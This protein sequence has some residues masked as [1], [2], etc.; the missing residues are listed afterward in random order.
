MSG[1]TRANGRGR[2]DD[3]SRGGVRALVRFTGE[4]ATKSRRTRARFQ[5]RLAS[6]LEA[7]F[8]SHGLDVRVERDWSRIYLSSSDRAF[9]DPLGRVFGVSSFSVLEAECA[10][11]LGEIVEVGRRVFAGRVKGRR[12]A[13][14]ARRTGSH[15]FGSADVM[16][17]LGAALNPG[18]TVD[19]DD[20]EVVVQVEVRGGR[21]S[22]FSDRIPGAGGLP[23][24][25][26][27][28]A[29]ALISGGFDSAVAAWMA[30]RRG[31]ELDYLFCNLGGAAYRRMVTEVAKVLS[32]SWSYGSDP[33]LHVVD[34]GEVVEA[35]RESAKPAYLQV[36]LKRLMYRAGSR[37]AEETG[38]E[39]LITG[40]SVGQV[41]SQTLTNLRAIDGAASVPVLRPL[42]GFDKEEIVERARRIG[43]HDLSARVRE[44]CAVAPD[45]PVTAARPEAAA[46]QEDTVDP[47]VLER[48][49]A[50]RDTVAL[51]SL[52]VADI[53][54]PSLFV[55]TIDED[56]AVVDTRPSEA[57]RHW[58]WPTAIHREFD[59]LAR[60]FGELDR[61]R[62]YVL[63]CTEGVRTAHLAEAMQ[64][65]G[66][67]AYSFRGG[68][69]ALRRH[70]EERLGDGAAEREDGGR[71]PGGATL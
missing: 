19:L 9:L 65:A 16:R 42:I 38:A 5:R 50:A 40:E 22:L 11:D 17:E 58:H 37:V 7:A 23:L 39:A 48:A 10:A 25:V 56:A 31:I 6:N 3:G 61:G 30:L 49:L 45:R 1:E 28:R 44:Y 51:G 20:P 24:G 35:M 68:I 41:S 32:D 64:A 52:E 60:R 2:V 57:Y 63:Y 71:A 69:R 12:Y 53:V 33:R 15:A 36:V 59:D 46:A 26:Q 4:L 47:D 70:A 8:R 67:E 62:T 27:G 66:Y 18:A 55:S 54:G 14:R 29:V 34:F 13:V 21:A 43:T